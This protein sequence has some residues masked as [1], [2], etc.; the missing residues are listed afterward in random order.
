METNPRSASRPT[1]GFAQRLKEDGRQTLE[2]RKRSAADRVDGIAQAIE[3]TGAQFVEN[4]PTL[5]DLANRLAGTVGNLATRLREGSID[6]LVEDTRT[7]ARRNPWLFILG[8]VVAGFALARFVK[9]S[10]QRRPGSEADVPGSGLA[11]DDAP[12]LM[13]E[14]QGATPRQPDTPP[15]A[16]PI[17]G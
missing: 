12:T 9:A 4:E 3:R 5:A 10:A 17:A 2:Q 11:A 7:F 6:D 8:G 15:G 14:V 1:S 16:S 13:D